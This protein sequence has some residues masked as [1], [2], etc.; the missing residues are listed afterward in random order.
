MQLACQTEETSL[1]GIL[2]VDAVDLCRTE[3]KLMGRLHQREGVLQADVN[4][5][6]GKVYIEY[7]PSR[8]SWEELR[9]LVDL[10]TS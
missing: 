5:R 10:S 6:A 3:K 8:V 4:C 1:V 9:R 7:N 2:R